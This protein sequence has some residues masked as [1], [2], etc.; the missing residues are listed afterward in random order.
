MGYSILKRIFV[1]S[2]ALVLVSCAEKE[3]LVKDLLTKT[4]DVDKQKKVS[5]KNDFSIEIPQN[6]TWKFTDYE[7]MN[8]DLFFSINSMSEIEEEKYFSA[9]VIGK[10]KGYSG[11]DDLK[12]EY[13]Y[14][15]EYNKDKI[16]DNVKFIESGKITIS[17]NTAYFI[18]TKLNTGTYGEDESITFIFKSKING[19]FYYIGLST[20]QTKDLEKNLMILLETLKTF[21]ILE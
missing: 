8:T 20:S 19:V 11:Q 12:T 14:M 2:I 1:F 7:K 5:P 9:M 21:K 6:W 16:L 15:M 4:I 17:N 10:K 13:E 18:H 3:F